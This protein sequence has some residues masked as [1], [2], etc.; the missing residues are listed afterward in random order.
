MGELK[1]KMVRGRLGVIWLRMYQKNKVREGVKT[2]AEIYMLLERGRKYPWLRDG[3]G[4]RE[5]HYR[6]ET[7]RRNQRKIVLINGKNAHMVQKQK[8]N[9]RKHNGWVKRAAQR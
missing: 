7:R 3:G 9:K 4:S 2:E 6:Q 1:T 5:V 8:K